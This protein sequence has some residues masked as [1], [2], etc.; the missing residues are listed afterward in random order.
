MWVI[1]LVKCPVWHIHEG[2][3]VKELIVVYGNKFLTN[4]CAPKLVSSRV[5]AMMV[6]FSQPL[7]SIEAG[8]C[9]YLMAILS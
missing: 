1:K 9:L 6:H 4:E 7:F 8:R 2:L 3:L 5:R